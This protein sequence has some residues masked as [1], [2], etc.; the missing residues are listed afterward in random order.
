MRERERRAASKGQKRN[1]CRLWWESMKN[2]QLERNRVNVG[3][4]K[5][6][7]NFTVQHAK[8]AREEGVD[9]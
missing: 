2:R 9:I 8:K 3:K 7:I 4:N 1:G 5:I 6:R